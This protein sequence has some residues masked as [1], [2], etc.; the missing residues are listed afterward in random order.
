[1]VSEEPSE[2]P[3]TEEGGSRRPARET[4]AGVI[5]NGA[6]IQYSIQCYLYIICMIIYQPAPEMLETEA[7][8]T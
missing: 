3:L 5:E 2:E 4:L 7:Y 1:M 6:I 8:V